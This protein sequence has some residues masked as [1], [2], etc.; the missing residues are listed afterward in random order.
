M[1]VALEQIAEA[2]QVVELL[3]EI[4]ARAIQLGEQGVERV[5]LAE[6]ALLESRKP[7]TQRFASVA[8]PL[9]RL[10]VAV[11]PTVEHAAARKVGLEQILQPRG[12]T[13]VLLGEEPADRVEVA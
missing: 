13:D 4:V 11:R 7:L 3:S 9:D 8:D 12:E 5:E 10:L 1:S 6:Q 2:R